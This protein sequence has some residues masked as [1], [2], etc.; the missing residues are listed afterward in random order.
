MPESLGRLPVL[1]NGRVKPLAVAARQSLQA[2]TGRSNFGITDNRGKTMSLA[3]KYPA[4]DVLAS[5]WRHPAAWRQL[6]LVEV[7]QIPLQEHLGLERWASI[8]SLT[9]GESM[10]FLRQ[11]QS[12][13]Q[14]ALATGQQRRDWDKLKDYGLEV[15]QGI[16]FAQAVLLGYGIDLIPVQSQ[17]QLDWVMSLDHR[18]LDNTIN[19]QAQLQETVL[20][21]YN[22]ERADWRKQAAQRVVETNIWISVR[23]AALAPDPLLLQWPDTLG[24]K[25]LARSWGEA[26]KSGD[27]VQIDSSTSALESGLFKLAEVEHLQGQGAG[28]HY[29]EPNV[30]GTELFYERSRIFTWVWLT[31]LLGGIIAGIAMARMKSKDAPWSPLLKCGIVVTAIGVGLNIWGFYLRLVIS[32]W[33]VVTNFYETFIYVAAVVAVLGVSM[34]LLFR[35]VYYLTFGAIGASLCAMV[36]EA[37]P[38]HLGEDISRLQPVLRSQFWLWVH[39]KVVTAAYGAFLLAWVMGMYVMGEAAFRAQ[40]V[41]ASSA[42]ALYR[43]LQIGIVLMVAGTILGAIWADEAWGRYWGW[44]PK[45]VWSG[46]HSRLPHPPPALHWCRAQYRHG[47]VVGLRLCLSGL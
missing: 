30:I 27:V 11:A 9:M 45:E 3:S 40:Q 22:S 2:V 47:G 7:P 33:G 42:H 10:N 25:A 15:A 17:A 23:D 21:F 14:H 18:H 36:G 5:W 16:P 37:M 32:D 46:D 4:M 43:C 35:N 24:I 29:P 28:E 38:A 12:I 1:H 20:P 13:A 39:V 8:D 31:Y 44:D 19:W 41:A 34:G 26:I 6:P